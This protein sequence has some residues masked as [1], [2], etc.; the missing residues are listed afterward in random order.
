MAETVVKMK[1]C[2]TRD[3]AKTSCGCTIAMGGQVFTCPECG[4]KSLSIRTRRRANWRPQ[5]VNHMKKKHG[6]VLDTWEDV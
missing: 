5:L 3:E 4:W 1:D 2:L 6:I